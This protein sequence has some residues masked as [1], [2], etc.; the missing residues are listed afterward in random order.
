MAYG[1]NDDAGEPDEV[2]HVGGE[3][4]ED[5][6]FEPAAAMNDGDEAESEY[7]AGGEGV[8][9]VLA[10]ADGEEGEEE[11]EAGDD[12]GVITQGV[13]DH[14][15]GDE[16]E[17]DKVDRFGVDYAGVGNEMH[18]VGDEEGERPSSADEGAGKDAVAVAAL[19]VDAGAENYEAD[20][21]AEADFFG[22]GE[23]RKFVGQ[24]KG[25]ADDEGDDA[26]L[27]E[28]VFAEG[29]LELGGRFARGEVR[30]LRRRGERR[31]NWTQ[32]SGRMRGG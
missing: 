2:I 4:A 15:R 26:E 13:K 27:V 7:G 17:E 25:D 21:I 9:R 31:R 30:G 10:Y 18:R 8:D 28:P 32:R 12:L 29:F 22:I 16:K 24:E 3:D 5:F 20:E 14:C 23:R 1:G 6:E 19:E 11:G